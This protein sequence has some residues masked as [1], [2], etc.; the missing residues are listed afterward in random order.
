MRLL[1][2]FDP[3]VVGTMRDAASVLV[4]AHKNRV[5]RCQGVAVTGLADG[6]SDRRRFEARDNRSVLTF[7]VE[8]FMWNLSRNQPSVFRHGA[9]TKPGNW[10]ATLEKLGTEVALNHSS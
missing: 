4:S 6:W 10:T 2:A 3:R 9:R 1:P 5:Y 7:H 8:R